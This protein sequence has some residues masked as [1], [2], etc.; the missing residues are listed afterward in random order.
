MGAAG[1]GAVAAGTRVAQA[2]VEGSY[3]EGV[4][5][6]AA[7]TGLA[8]GEAAS[9]SVVWLPS[10]S[11]E[12]PATRR[13]RMVMYNLAGTVLAEREVDLKPFTGAS[14]NYENSGRRRQAV[15]QYTF[16]DQPFE[17]IYTGTEI[18]DVAS[19]ITSR[20]VANPIG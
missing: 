4:S 16:V 7:A 12:Q 6:M 1:L 14:L 11:S 9:M 5:P 3:S 19:G 15:F 13:V 17:G 18:Y 2:Q 8:P 20:G 10:S